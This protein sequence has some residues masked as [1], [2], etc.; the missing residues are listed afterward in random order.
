V[1]APTDEAF[2]ELE[3]QNPGTLNQLLS[4]PEMLRKIL[5]LHVVQGEVP[6]SVA[7]GLIGQ[8]AKS[9][10]GL[11]L[12]FIAGGPLG[13]KVNNASVTAV[14]NYAK[15]GVIHVVDAVILPQE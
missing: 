3:R 9:V 4:N 7:I 1:F 2:A 11:D 12:S 13:L 15:N 8:T 5:L 6:S 10:N 14:D